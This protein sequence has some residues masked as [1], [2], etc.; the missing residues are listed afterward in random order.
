[1]TPAFLPGLGQARWR[2]PAISF[3]LRSVLRREYSGLFGLIA[4]FAVLEL[5]AGYRVSGRLEWTRW[6][7]ALFTL[8]AVVYLLLLVLKRHT[9]VLKI[10]G[11]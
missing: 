6:W 11:R 9:R 2:P 10:E 3:S 4:T 7:A 5:V 1:V 8:G